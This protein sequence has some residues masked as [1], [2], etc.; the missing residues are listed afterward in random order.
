MGERNLNSRPKNVQ[1]IVAGTKGDLIRLNSRVR[2]QKTANLRVMKAKC[3]IHFGNWKGKK[4]VGVC[5]AGAGRRCV[6][7][8]SEYFHF[9]FE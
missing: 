4:K 7:K 9:F 3:V 6:L 1:L 8:L 5:R 2:I